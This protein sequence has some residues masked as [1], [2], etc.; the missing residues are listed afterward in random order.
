[1]I[2]IISYRYHGPGPAEKKSSERGKTF[3]LSFSAVSSG[4]GLELL[5]HSTQKAL[6]LMS[7]SSRDRIGLG[8]ISLFPS[9]YFFGFF[10]SSLLM[11]R[12]LTWPT[13]R[14]AIRPLLDDIIFLDRLI[15]RLP[16]YPPFYRLTWSAWPLYWRS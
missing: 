15:R 7:V 5:V 16:N 11:K 10:F 3:S 8:D 6:T 1:M 9:A 14:L 12:K 4:R 13:G 2:F